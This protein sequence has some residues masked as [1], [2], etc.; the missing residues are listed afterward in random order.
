MRRLLSEGG[1]TGDNGVMSAAIDVDGEDGD[2]D[3]DDGEEGDDGGAAVF[4]SKTL[5]ALSTLAT[6][7]TTLSRLAVRVPEATLN[8]SL[9]ASSFTSLVSVALEASSNTE[10]R[11]A[12]VEN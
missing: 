6:A 12:K 7:V 5:T 11:E 1:I 2:P 8:V 3:D 4:L 9:S 10:I